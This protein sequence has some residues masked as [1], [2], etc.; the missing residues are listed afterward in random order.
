[1]MHVGV[2]RAETTTIKIESWRNGRN[3]CMTLGVTIA[4]DMM[5]ILMP[6]NA[7]WAWRTNSSAIFTLTT[8]VIVRGAARPNVRDWCWAFRA[9][10]PSAKR[11]S[12]DISRQCAWRR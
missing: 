7:K 6:A 5:S 11:W 10:D 12:I 8:I 1:M 4:L 2:H 3:K 9:I